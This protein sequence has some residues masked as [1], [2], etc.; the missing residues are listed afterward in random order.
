MSQEELIKMQQQLF[1]QAKDRARADM[2]PPQ[3]G[4]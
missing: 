2:V 3:D 4:G 1:Q